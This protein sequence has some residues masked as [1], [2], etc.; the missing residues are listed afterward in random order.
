MSNFIAALTLFTLGLIIYLIATVGVESQDGKREVCKSKGLE[1]V[2]IRGQ[3]FC[4]E[5]VN[6]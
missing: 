6:R 5:G 3:E 1:Y 2:S 4:A